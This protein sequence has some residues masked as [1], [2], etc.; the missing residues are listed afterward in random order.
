[1]A[2]SRLFKAL[3]DWHN[4]APKSHRRSSPVPPSS[5]S[6][7]LK[8]LEVLGK[9]TSHQVILTMPFEFIKERL[10][11][12]NV[13]NFVSKH[14]LVEGGELGKKLESVTSEYS[15]TPSSGGGYNCKVVMTFKLLPG[16]QPINEDAKAKEAV[17]G[18]IKAAEAYLLFNPTAYA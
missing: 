9:S 7:K 10:D 2:A 11:F 15:F 6:M 5:P 12:V 13:D 1:M 4:L 17:T 3:L 18:V 8:V 16:V 14:S